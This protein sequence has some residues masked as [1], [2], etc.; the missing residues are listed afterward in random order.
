M[1]EEMIESVPWES[2]EAEYPEAED[3]IYEAE[4][5]AE[6]YRRPRR[7][8]RAFQPARGVQG[9]TLRGREGTRRVQFPSNLTTVTE[10]NKLALAGRALDQR[11]D[12]LESR[13]RGQQ[14]KDVAT[15]GAVALAV[16]GGLSVMGA[17]QAANQ[18]STGS[19]LTNWASRDVTQMAAVVSVTQLATSG[20]RLAFNGRYT[21]SG[22]GISAD[23]FSLLQLGLF[24]FGTLHTTTPAQVSTG[25]VNSQNTVTY[26]PGTEILEVNTGNL[27]RVIQTT[28]GNYPVLISLGPGQVQA[29]Q[30]QAA[31]VRAAQA[32]PAPA[33][34]G[35]GN[36][37]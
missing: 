37:G 27:Y 31:Q 17:F 21:R 30:A 15:T 4:D 34:A 29:A 7:Q 10:T 12:R 23:A 35:P 25:A 28:A 9:L 11:L 33:K 36:P 1:A 32:N 6:D 24:T 18:P 19:A 13:F 20:A 3:A 2:E 16:G 22:F 5:S 14:K 26:P 8:R